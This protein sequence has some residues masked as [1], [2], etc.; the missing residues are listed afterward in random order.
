VIARDQEKPYRF[1]G[2]AIA[3]AWPR[4]MESAIA[5]DSVRAKQA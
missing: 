2:A 4:V 5:S 3:M 1:G